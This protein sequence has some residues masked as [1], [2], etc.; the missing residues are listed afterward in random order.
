MGLDENLALR[1]LLAL[2]GGELEELSTAAT[3]LR[4][5]GRRDGDHGRGR[6]AGVRQ[7]D[8][9]RQPAAQD[10]SEVR[11]DR[12][13]RVQVFKCCSGPLLL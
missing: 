10:A 2:S 5:H 9:P 6:G 11:P 7:E 4:Q 13:F 8:H 12:I 1:S 3:Q